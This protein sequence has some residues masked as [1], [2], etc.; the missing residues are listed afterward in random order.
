MYYLNKG[1]KFSE[2]KRHNATISLFI[3]H[4][5]ENPKFVLNFSTIFFISNLN[6]SHNLTSIE[7]T[8][9]LSNPINIKK[10]NQTQ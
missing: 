2:K 7:N 8:I 10:L 1:R 6:N 9:N 5:Q 4:V 3:I